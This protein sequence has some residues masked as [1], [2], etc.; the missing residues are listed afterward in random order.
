M[1][2]P[3]TPQL[4]AVRFVT[5]IQFA[6]T[7]DSVR[8]GANG[9]CLSV[10]PARIGPDL[11]PVPTDANQPSQGLLIRGKGGFITQSF[12]AWANVAEMTYGNG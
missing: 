4:I 2:A 10:Q 7:T 3:K 11:T 12:V 5:P 8:L 6:G 1:N 9:N